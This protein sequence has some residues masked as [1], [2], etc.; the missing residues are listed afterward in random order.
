MQLTDQQA[1]DAAIANTARHEW[2]AAGRADE[3]F[4]IAERLTH[5]MAILHEGRQ[6][7]SL[8]EVYRILREPTNA[9]N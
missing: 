2:L 8:E 3:R 7:V 5:L 9:T 4:R 6:Y 1:E